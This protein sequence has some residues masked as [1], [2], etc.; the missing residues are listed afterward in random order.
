MAEKVLLRHL[1]IPEI[2]KLAVYLGLGA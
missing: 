1:D 2:R